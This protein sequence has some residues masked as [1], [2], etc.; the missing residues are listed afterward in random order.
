MDCFKGVVSPFGKC[1]TRSIRP[2]L[3]AHTWCLLAV[4]GRQGRLHRMAK[5]SRIVEVTAVR[6]AT[7][8][9]GGR[10][11]MLLTGVAALLA[12]LFVFVPEG[13]AMRRA[14]VVE[15][16]WQVVAENFFDPE[17][18]GVDWQKV[19]AE[20]AA[21]AAQ[22]EDDEALAAVINE[23]LAKLGDP[24]TYYLTAKQAA[25][26][27][28][29]ENRVD[30]VGVGMLLGRGPQGE[31]VV[32]DVLP[33]GPAA[34]ARVRRGERIT[35]VDGEEVQGVRVSDV[36]EKIRGPKSST[37][38]LT[39]LSDKG[40]RRVLAKRAPVSFIPEVDSKVL[41][42]NIGYLKIPD[43]ADSTEVQV[44]AH[45]RRLHRTDGL[46][47]DLRDN[48]GGGGYDTLL[49]IA[50]LFTDKPLGALLSRQGLFVLVP[51]SQWEGGTGS[52][53]VPPPTG[54]DIYKKPMAVIVDE[55]TY[56]E[57][58]AVGLQETGRAKL[59]GR[60]TVT[61]AMRQVG[62][63]VPR[64]TS[65][66]IAELSDGS[67]VNVTSLHVITPRGKTLIDGISPDVTVSMDQTFY[68]AWMAGRDRDVEEAVKLLQQMIASAE[69]E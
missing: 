33:N 32:R 23:M 48:F 44:L 4:S 38:A 69:K 55:T 14:E 15:E 9:K 51:Q 39:L 50:G 62:S 65:Q 40:E 42:G 53:F 3:L 47:L 13:K 19:K 66:Y 28:R 56:L 43:F 27:E 46:V 35:A 29:Q 11:V 41:E 20:Y 25:E 64:G 58:L 26:L 60:P 59:V 1:S 57:T 67:V 49:K 10:Q 36:A 18:N 12:A 22:A 17:F 63:G 6:G 2:P 7:W 37:V 52:I 34:R 24:Q 54:M 5:D 8:F 30:I 68:E 16:V 61:E 21:K 31:I 45:L